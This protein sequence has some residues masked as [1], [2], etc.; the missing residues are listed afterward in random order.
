MREKILELHGLV[1]G[2]FDNM[3]NTI[4]FDSINR[5]AL[6]AEVKSRLAEY[7]GRL[8]PFDVVVDTIKDSLAAIQDITPD[9]VTNLPPELQKLVTITRE[10]LTAARAGYEDVVAPIYERLFDETD[11][12]ALIVFLKSNTNQQLREGGLLNPALTNE[13]VDELAAFLKSEPGQ[14]YRVLHIEL[15]NELTVAT[16]NWRNAALDGKRDEI[17]KILG[18][19]EPPPAVDEPPSGPQ[20]A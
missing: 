16:A 8:P 15:Q 5:Q 10:S 20:A 6:L 4:N 18:F 13:E 7:N 19:D 1:F 11:V 17:A 14:K 2:T 9:D 3:V 12:D